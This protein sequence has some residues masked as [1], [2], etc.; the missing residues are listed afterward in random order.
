MA[1]VQNLKG[2]KM[3]KKPDTKAGDTAKPDEPAAPPP[4]T[5]KQPLKAHIG[6]IPPNLQQQFAGKGTKH[7]NSNQANKGRNFRHQGR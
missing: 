5:E 3:P 1:I 7:M 4:H 2:Y 6:G